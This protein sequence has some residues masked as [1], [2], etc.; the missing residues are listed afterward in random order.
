MRIVGVLLCL[1]L[2]IS[3]NKERRFNRNLQGTWEV[4]MVK[5]QDKDGFS[6]FDY[7]PQ[8][9]LQIADNTVQ[10][11]L[12]ASFQTF[13]GVVADTLSLQGTYELNLA[14]SELNWIQ[15]SDTLKNR[16]FVITNKNLEIEH[17]DATSQLRLRYVF[18]KVK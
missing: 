13:Q 12:T 9:N 18:K 10:G 6:F 1:M 7:N 14:D 8:G 3:C 11:K 2:L 16:I 17:Y 4:D 5:L 15:A